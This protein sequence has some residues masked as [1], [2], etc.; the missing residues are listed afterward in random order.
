[1]RRIQEDCLRA[2]GIANE[3][4]DV[5]HVRAKLVLLTQHAVVNSSAATL[6]VGRV[7][8][9][10]GAEDQNVVAG[11]EHRL[12]EELLEDLG[13]GA[14]YHVFRGNRDAEV[15]GVVTGNRLAKTG[16]A[17]RRAIMGGVLVDRL[18]A[19]S[20]RVRRA[21]ERAITDLQLDDIFAASLQP[22]GHRQYIKRGFAG[23]ALGKLAQSE[24]FGHRGLNSRL[25]F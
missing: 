19:G 8:W 12:A 18:D 21:G 23:E 16:E 2:F 6:D 11:I 10:I 15:G 13:A 25:Q 17:G 3:V 14:N 20:Q 9:E 4:L 22:L 5:V 7:R 24:R 1:M